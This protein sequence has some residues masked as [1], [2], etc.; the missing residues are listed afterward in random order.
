MN[1]SN[2][3]QHKHGFADYILFFISIGL[4]FILAIVALAKGINGMVLTAAFTAIS[5]IIGRFSVK[6][7]K[8]RENRF[9]EDKYRRMGR[10]DT[11]YYKGD[12]HG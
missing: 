11:Q 9:Y 1:D 7:L 3:K 5:F 12:Y 2:T 4:V 10:N 6:I 8:F